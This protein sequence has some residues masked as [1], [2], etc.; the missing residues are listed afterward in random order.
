MALKAFL[1]KLNIDLLDQAILADF[2]T[3]RL[4]G[5]AKGLINCTTSHQLKEV[6]AYLLR[7]NINFIIIGTGSNLVVSDFGVDCYVIR[8][9]SDTPIIEY[10]KNEI[11]VS[12]STRLD[13][14]VKFSVKNGLGG[15]CFASGIP[16]TVGGAIAGNAGAFGKQISDCLDSVDLINNLGEEKRAA[17]NSLNFSYRNSA[18]KNTQ[19]II[20]SARFYLMPQNRNDLRKERNHNLDI[21]K[22]KHPD[23][24]KQH[25]A[26]SF[27]KNIEH[28]ACNGT[29]KRHSAGRFLEEAGAKSLNNGGTHVFEKHANIIIANDAATSQDVFDLS[30]E[31]VRVVQKKFNFTLEREVRFVGKFKGMPAG[32]NNFFW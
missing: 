12:A 7:E 29:G 13:D 2:T 20:L 4:G 10:A 24:N 14:L 30:K 18:F 17:A 6:L 1:K 23:W 3:F 15:L 5:M 22:T 19:N 27:F 11:V 31:M 8:Y 9:F 28:R 21:R 16:G 25:C 26:G 32:I